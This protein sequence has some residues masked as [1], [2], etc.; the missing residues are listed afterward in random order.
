MI[1]ETMRSY[2]ENLYNYSESEILSDKDTF[3]INLFNKSFFENEKLIIINHI[4]EKILEVIKD[5]VEKKDQSFKIILKAGILEKKSKLRNF[6]EKENNLII[7]AFYEDDHQTLLN[8]AQNFFRENAIKISTQNINFILEKTK[9]SRLSLKNELIKI[10]NL[11]HSR[12][13]IGF[14]DII[15]LINP[16]ENY[17]ISELTDQCL[18][19]DKGKTINFLN[20]NNSSIE[21]NILILKSFLHKL[22]RLKFLKK[23]MEK[24]K[25]ED[26]VISSYR[27]PIFWKDKELI[28]KQLKI[29]SLDEIKLLIKKINKLEL[30]IKKNSNLSNQILNDFI[31]ER[32]DASNNWI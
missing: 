10:K 26:Q 25:S 24:K 7:T 2:T 18:A 31:F 27:P 15:K 22:K 28:K 30:T 9:G 4:T 14:D 20:E 11:S 8:F 3:I 21:E 12:S 32:L 6:F 13:S 17:K 23:E 5:I 1:K 29:W 19:K 16:A